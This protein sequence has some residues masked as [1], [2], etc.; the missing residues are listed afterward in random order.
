MIGFR[1]LF[2]QEWQDNAGIPRGTGSAYLVGAGIEYQ[3]KP[4]VTLRVLDIEIQKWPTYNVTG[5][6]PIVVSAGAAY[7]FR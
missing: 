5:I 1:D 2:I 6:N 7:R 3:L 4:T